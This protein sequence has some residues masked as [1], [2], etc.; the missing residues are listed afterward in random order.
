MPHPAATAPGSADSETGG[1]SFENPERPERPER[2]AKFVAVSTPTADQD[3][4]I[5]QMFAENAKPASVEI[6][7]SA[8]MPG[9]E[10]P[11]T[12]G[13]AEAGG[14]VRIHSDVSS[15]TTDELGRKV[16]LRQQQF[17]CMRCN[18]IAKGTKI[19]TGG[20]ASDQRLFNRVTGK[21]E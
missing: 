9:I 4:R 16:P 6:E 18:V 10:C 2:P 15:M 14:K 3:S 21:T 11:F 7:A 5:A 8:L 19:I 17:R 1:L 13:C 12:N 20:Q